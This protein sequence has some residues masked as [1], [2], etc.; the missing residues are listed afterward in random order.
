[1]PR[2]ISPAQEGLLIARLALGKAGASIARGLRAVP[3]I[4]LNAGA[5]TPSRLDLA[6][7]DIRPADAFIADQIYS[8]MFPLAGRI[9]HT[10]GHSPFTLKMPSPR[11]A[12]E[13][14]GFRW[15]RPM[16][17]NLPAPMHAR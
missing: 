5:R 1:M 9:L 7:P 4:G 14:H 16:E 6:L 11:F 2:S 3:Q 12:R 13:L 10:E 8:G 15:F 17:Q